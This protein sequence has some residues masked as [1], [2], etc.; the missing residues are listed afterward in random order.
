MWVV[1]TVS[2]D[3]AGLRWSSAAGRTQLVVSVPVYLRRGAEG[4]LTEIALG[5]CHP[6]E[7]AGRHFLYL[8]PSAAVFALDDTSAAVVDTLRGRQLAPAELMA[9][10]AG[11]FEPAEVEATLSELAGA[12]AILPVDPARPRSRRRS[13]PPTSF[14]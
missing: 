5:E 6:F 7:A 1:A 8:V 9:L 11:R 14:P 10:L 4:T 13:P 3:P 2:T 12:R